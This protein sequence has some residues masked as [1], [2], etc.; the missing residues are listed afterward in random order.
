MTRL[1][2]GTALARGLF[3]RGQLLPP[4]AMAVVLRFELVGAVDHL[5][6]DELVGVVDHLVRAELVEVVDHL[7]RDYGCSG[8][9]RRCLV[10]V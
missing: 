5:V 7:V 10:L 1:L 3:L 2:Q 9:G 8:W 4:I 6:L